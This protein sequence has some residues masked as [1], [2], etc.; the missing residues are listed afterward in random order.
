LAHGRAE[1]IFETEAIFA[2]A[3]AADGLPRAINQLC[4]HALMLATARGIRPV[5]VETVLDSL[6]E[7]QTLPLHW[8][9]PSAKRA[10]EDEEISVGL[11]SPKPSF[12]EFHHNDSTN[13]AASIEVGSAWDELETTNES[14]LDVDASLVND[15]EE[16]E[17]ILEEHLDAGYDFGEEDFAEEDVAEEDFLDEEIDPVLDARLAQLSDEE[18]QQDALAEVS[19]LNDVRNVQL[20]DEY[21]ET[22]AERR[23]V[24]RTVNAHV[25]DEPVRYTETAGVEVRPS[26]TESV[27]TEVVIDRYALIDA[28]LVERVREWERSSQKAIAMTRTENDDDVYPLLEESPGLN[29]VAARQNVALGSIPLQHAG[30]TGR[31]VTPDAL[32]QLKDNLPAGH[33]SFKLNRPKSA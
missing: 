6:E 24:A 14:S 9:T 27:N 25:D 22:A 12:E 19:L 17:E 8:R 29:Q 20:K 23:I 13:S 26:S 21:E 16:L 3:E 1:T 10:R 33:V 15:E 30:E 11:N 28:G 2:I 7:L 32:Q 31:E 5:D 4:D 18:I